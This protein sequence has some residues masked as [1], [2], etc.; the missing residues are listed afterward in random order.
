MHSIFVFFLVCAGKYAFTLQIQNLPCL[1]DE[2]KKD[3]DDARKEL[4]TVDNY[5]GKTVGTLE[6][7]VQKTLNN[8]KQKLVT[9]KSTVGKIMKKVETDL[10]VLKKDL[11]KGQWKKYQGHCYYYASL[12]AAWY[13]AER[14]CRDFGGYLVKI[15]NS[16][17]NE[18]VYSASKY[19]NYY[20]WIGLSDLIEGEW[21]WSIDQSLATFKA[22]QSGYGSKGHSSNCV[23][24]KNN[25]SKWID[26]NCK[27]GYLYICERNFC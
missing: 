15:D 3:L 6:N 24:F 22:W 4:K 7:D 16:S 21:R 13:K 8:M 2:S 5:L 10:V 18:W 14:L 25:K 17:E 12:G 27:I 26:T 11:K 9:M 1:T 20:Y 23:A 19:K